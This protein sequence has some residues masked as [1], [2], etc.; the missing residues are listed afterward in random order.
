MRQRQ[1]K[2]GHEMPANRG[3]HSA[4]PLW[5]SETSPIEGTA[6]IPSFVTGTGRTL[7]V[8][9]HSDQLRA[10]GEVLLDLADQRRLH[11]DV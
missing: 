5:L 2:L 1:A 3:A 6:G 10:L 7:R 9:L 11:G 4:Y 8:R